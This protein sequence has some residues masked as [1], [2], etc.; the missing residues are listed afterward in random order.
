MK[1]RLRVW[2]LLLIVGIVAV[3]VSVVVRESQKVF[4]PAILKV[5]VASALP[6]RPITGDRLVRPDGTISLGYYGSIQ[7]AG[8]TPHEIRRAVAIHLRRY[9]PDATVDDVSVFV[10]MTS[11]RRP[12][13]IDWMTGKARLNEV[14]TLF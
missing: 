1:L 12:R 9:L 2:T 14:R 10:V 7:V 13:L 4:A 5:E 6:G 8:L 3:L 11:F